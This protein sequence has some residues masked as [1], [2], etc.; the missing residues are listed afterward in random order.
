VVRGTS[1]G[2]EYWMAF[3]IFCEVDADAFRG[4]ASSVFAAGFL[5]WTF[6]VEEGD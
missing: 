4:E 3:D 1:D 2:E 5:N 6:R